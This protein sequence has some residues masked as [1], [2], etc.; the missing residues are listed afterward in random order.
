[1]PISDAVLSE[2]TQRYDAACAAYQSCL[3]ALNEAAMSGVSPSE[4]LIRND[5]KAL[6][7]LTEARS[8]LLSAKRRGA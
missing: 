4:T 8:K 6:H 5:A 2:L 1:M 7:E 3:A